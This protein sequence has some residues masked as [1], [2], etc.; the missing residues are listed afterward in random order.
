MHLH[1]V[2]IFADEKVIIVLARLF[3]LLRLFQ[4]LRV[5]HCKLGCHA[6]KLGR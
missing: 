2:A 6:C 5:R 3:T 1:E 4:P